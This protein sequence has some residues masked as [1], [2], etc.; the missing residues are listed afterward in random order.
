MDVQ[1]V[2]TVVL[3]FCPGLLGLYG[4]W[5]CHDEAVP[6]LPVSL[7]VFYKLTPEVSTELPS[8]LRHSYFHR[9]SEYGLTVLP[10][11]PKTRG[12]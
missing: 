9:A 5:H 3:E 6:L 10:K 12:A 1:K 2:P 7:D 4:L 8:T 11:N